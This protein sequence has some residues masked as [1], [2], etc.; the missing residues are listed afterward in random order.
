VRFLLWFGCLGKVTHF[1]R[2]SG[3]FRDE[4]GLLRGAQNLISAFDIGHRVAE[5]GLFR[6]RS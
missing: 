1:D 6:D 5:V 2:S 4:C 3:K